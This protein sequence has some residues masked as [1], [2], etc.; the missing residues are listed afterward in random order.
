MR[1]KS[2][3]FGHTWPLSFLNATVAPH[4]Q[5]HSG[6]ITLDEGSIS[7]MLSDEEGN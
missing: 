2:A 5:G 3:R 7:G 6:P 4:I 1:T